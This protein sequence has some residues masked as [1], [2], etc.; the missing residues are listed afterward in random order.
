MSATIQGI[1]ARGYLAGWLGGLVDMYSKDIKALPADKWD[2]THGG[3]TRSAAELT[4]DA[5]ALLDWTTDALKGNVREYGMDDIA[6]MKEKINSP[7]AAI[8]QLSTSADAFNAALAGASDD[9][10][11]SIVTPPWKMD[12]PL[13]ILAQVAVSHIWYHDGQLNYIQALLGDGEVHWMD[14]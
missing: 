12:A 4:A 13:Y 9:A 11:N 5:I 3:S 6:S 7:Q 2:A 14:A 1:D 10:L 8:S